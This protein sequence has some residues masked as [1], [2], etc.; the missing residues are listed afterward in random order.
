MSNDNNPLDI[1]V[2]GS[3]YKTFK[4]QPVEFSNANNLNFIQGSILKY[5]CRYNK[6]TGKGVQDLE[7]IIH[8]SQLA[9]AF[10]KNEAIV[11]NME[12]IPRQTV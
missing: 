6:P 8:Y 1:Q 12:D 9:I 2:G 4:I 10:L 7:K 3:H 11:E 5:L